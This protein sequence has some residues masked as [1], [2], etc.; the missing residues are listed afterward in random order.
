MA[1]VV[2]LGTGGE[3]LL[4]VGA[5]VQ[6]EVLILCGRL[7]RQV[8]CFQQ[9]IPL[10]VDLNPQPAYAALHSIVE[11]AV[12]ENEVDVV[13]EVLHLG[14]DVERELLLIMLL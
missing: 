4:N 9:L 3:D 12:V 1:G 7:L 10:A 5:L 8:V 14:V 6:H 13:Y 2:W 11:P